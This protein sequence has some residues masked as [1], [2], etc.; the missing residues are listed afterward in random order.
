[1]LDFFPFVVVDLPTFN[2]M[3]VTLVVL[4]VILP[5]FIVLIPLPCHTQK[6]NET[7]RSNGAGWIQRTNQRNGLKDGT[8][9]EV[10]V[11]ISFELKN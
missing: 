1:M 5:S 10:Y 6:Q 11:G 8:Y 3:G 2:H 4:L 7:K 9:E